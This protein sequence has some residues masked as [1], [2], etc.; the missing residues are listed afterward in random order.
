ML[1]PLLLL[2]L[3]APLWL[4]HLSGL[5]YS[6]LI[7]IWSFGAGNVGDEVLKL[8]LILKV[9]HT[10]TVGFVLLS[11]YRIWS[12]CVCSLHQLLSSISQYP[13]GAIIP[14]QASFSRIPPKLENLASSS[15]SW[16]AFA[17]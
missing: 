17:L 11:C 4:R 5:L 13:I 10:T 14:L 7:L 1:L 8:S 2:I 3:T 12:S 6:S 16:N 15:C 9:V